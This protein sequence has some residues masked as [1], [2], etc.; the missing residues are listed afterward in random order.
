MIDFSY[1]CYKAITMSAT[2]ILREDVKR[3][4]SELDNKTLRILQAILDIEIGPDWD[5]MPEELRIMLEAS[6][7]ETERIPHEEMVKKYP[8]LDF[9]VMEG[10]SMT[11]TEALCEEV[12][13]L[14]DMSDD[15]ALRMVKAVL[16][17]RREYGFRH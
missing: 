9:S 11:I 15:R 14:V 16:E 3:N 7:N 10:K 4:L 8:E 2:E 17:I 12:M 6:E 1:I 5:E 13:D